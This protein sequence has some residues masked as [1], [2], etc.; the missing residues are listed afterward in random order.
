MQPQPQGPQ[1]WPV[2]PQQMM[3]P[4]M[5]YAGFWMRFLAFL[6]DW[7]ILIAAFGVLFVIALLIMGGGALFSG[8]ESVEDFSDALA[9]VGVLLLVL[10]ILGFVV[11]VWLYFAKSESSASQATI[12]KRAVGIYVTDLNGQRITFGRA[13]GRVFSCIITR[14]IPL[15]IGYIMAAFTEK[16]Q[17][18]HD[19]I[20]STLVLRRG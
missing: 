10:L 16:K 17:A 13:S 7:V 8:N 3:V 15:A 14:M 4:Q 1:G 6:I 2:P 12:G 20:A 5:P 11:G 9:G 18:L 19:M